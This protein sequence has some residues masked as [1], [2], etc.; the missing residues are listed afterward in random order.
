MPRRNS[1][2][3]LAELLVSI[4]ILALLL[5]LAGRIVSSASNLASN[6]SK[7]M[8]IDAQARGILN[9]MAVDFSMMIMRADVDSYSKGADP[10]TGNDRIA[11]FSNV[12]GY[13]P[14]GSPSSLSLVAYRVNR[15]TKVLE[16]LGKG[17]LWNGVSTTKRPIIF[18]AAGT[19]AA[20]WPWVTDD[21]SP[22]PDSDFETIGPQV[23]RFEYCYLLKTGALANT[24]GA[25]GWQDVAAIGVALAG[26][27]RKSRGLLNDTQIDR[28]QSNL[29]DFDPTEPGYDLADSWQTALNTTSDMP[30]VA[31]AAIRIYQRYF[32]L[33]PK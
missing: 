31:V 11:L 23:F 14:N 8:D 7:R 6:A 3:T 2:F 15:N 17:L 13:Y 18:G 26:I 19:V 12:P 32:S 30:R 5:V 4:T 10:Q 21:S 29:K 28:L 20:T 1:A 9:R 22:D 24:P 33:V 16:R 27:D 25:P